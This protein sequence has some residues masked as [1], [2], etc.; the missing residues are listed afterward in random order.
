[1][2]FIFVYALSDFATSIPNE[3][4]ALAADTAPFT[5]TT[6]A[7]LT[8]IEVEITNADADVDEIG[9][10]QVLTNDI[11][12]GGETFTAGSRIFG[13]YRL[14]NG[15]DPDLI[16]VTA[17]GGGNNGANPTTFVAT[18]VP[19]EPNTA[20]V[21]TSESNFNGDDEPYVCF[22]SG[23]FIETE[24][25]L[26]SVENL[27]VGDRILT[28]D[29]GMQPIRWIGSRTLDSIDLHVN[30][31]LK[32]IRIKSSAL[33]PN[34]PNQ[35]L[36][37]SPQHRILVPSIV[38]QRVFGTTEVLVSAKKLLDLDGIDIEAN[39]STVIYHHFL[40]NQHEIV[41]SNGV[42]T[43]CQFTG[44]EA[45]KSV[46][47][48][49]GKEI[50]A[51]FPEILAEDFAPIA[52]RHVPNRGKLMLQLAKRLKKATSSWLKLTLGTAGIIRPVIFNK[53]GH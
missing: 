39:T 9:V 37:V 25:G 35:D 8:R 46:G 33:A 21:Y 12:I 3:A 22:V 19:L 51:L 34:L 5:V 42:P 30:P 17:N 10:T 40:F 29:H 32:P 16:S 7:T 18:T 4:G 52:A 15:T 45:M 6:G 14:S 36:L 47:A 53:V 27:Q 50:A 49:P 43:E 11:V 44:K 41:L 23:T 1:M 28:M 20:Y 13:N 48:E 24:T 2:P 38:A 31:Q 26:T